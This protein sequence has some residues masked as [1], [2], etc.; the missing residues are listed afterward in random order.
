MRIYRN[1]NKTMSQRIHSNEI[2]YVIKLNGK[3]QNNVWDEGRMSN[4]HMSL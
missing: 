1:K 2:N 3:Q 4:I